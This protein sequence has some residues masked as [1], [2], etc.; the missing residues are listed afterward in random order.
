MNINLIRW[1][2]PSPVKMLCLLDSNSTL[3]TVE[4]GRGELKQRSGRRYRRDHKYEGV[5]Q[6]WWRW[7]PETG[8]DNLIFFS[9]IP[10][11][12]GFPQIGKR[13]QDL[14]RMQVRVSCNRRGLLRYGI[15]RLL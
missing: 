12:R 10:G 3:Y 9:Y 14:T 4:R 15:G 7:L 11:A 5:M 13:R 1:N 8:D 6:K 2:T